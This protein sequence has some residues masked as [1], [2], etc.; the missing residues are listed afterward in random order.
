MTAPVPARRVLRTTR[1]TRR[2]ALTLAL[3]LA[4]LG[5]GLYL[6]WVAAPPP[7]AD[8]ALDSLA[9]HYRAEYVRLTAHAYRATADLPTAHRRLQALGVSADTVR[10]LFTADLAARAPSADLQALAALAEALGV[11]TP[12]MQAYLP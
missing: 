1:A 11:T 8:T 12:A 2:W 7:V 3:W 10:D 6:G 5:A 9:P 4:G